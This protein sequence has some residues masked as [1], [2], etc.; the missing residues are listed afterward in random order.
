MTSI[1]LLTE[2]IVTCKW[3][4]NHGAPRLRLLTNHKCTL[5]FSSQSPLW[6]HKLWPERHKY[7]T[8]WTTAPLFLNLISR[9][10][11]LWLKL[12]QEAALFHV[13]FHSQ[14][15]KMDIF[16]R[17]SLI[18]KELKLLKS[19]LRISKERTSPQIGEMLSKMDSN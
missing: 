13:Q 19:F 3:L 9:Q 4:I 6:L 7:C 11:Q 16:L 1:K 15:E 8:L 2:P 18:K 5:T 14:L 10:D 12:E 17:L